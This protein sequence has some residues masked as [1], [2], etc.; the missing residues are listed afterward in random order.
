MALALPA[1]FR[2][3]PL[4]LALL[5]ATML[6]ALLIFALNF[7][8]PLGH[9]P[10]V[11]EVTLALHRSDKADPKADFLAQA[12]QQGGGAANDARLLTSQEQS[13]FH[14]DVVNQVQPLQQQAAAPDT[15]QLQRQ[16]IT[17]TGRSPYSHDNSQ[18]QEPPRP[19]P[20]S[21]QEQQEAQLSQEI[22][23]LEA[24][25][26]A[27]QNAYAKRA[28]VHRVDSISARADVAAAYIDAFRSQVEK[29]GNQNYPAEA[30]VRHW[31]GNVRLLVT[32]RA[33]GSIAEVEILQ[34]SGRRLLDQAAVRS[35]R[36][37]APFTPFTRDMQRDM[38]TLQI[39]RTWKFTETLSSE[40]G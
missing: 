8:M 21:P 28:R 14:T 29:V 2:N 39:I 23:T 32:L 18:V 34:S 9:V 37:A 25:V 40:A 19:L 20:P 26:A 33:D 10:H 30:R 3:D 35:V 5:I 13:P 38:D 31:V 4:P 24:R 15:E 11:M 36:L 12:N 27:E 17:T 7:H 16:V 6:H 1:R 22:A